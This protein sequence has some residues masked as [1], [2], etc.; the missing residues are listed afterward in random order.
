MMHSAAGSGRLLRQR[1]QPVRR[2]DFITL[3]GGAAAWPLA[4]GAQQSARPVIGYLYGGSAES[5]TP[6]LTGFRRGLMESGYTEGKNVSVE[7][8]WADSQVDRLPKLAE[9]LIRGQVAV[10]PPPVCPLRAQPLWQ[11][12]RSR[13]SYCSLTSPE[14]IDVCL[15]R[16]LPT[17]AAT[18]TISGD[19]RAQC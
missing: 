11:P 5:A 14:V 15:R 2:R 19:D 18:L 17:V 8:R 1:G 16:L 4:A 12:R 9:E 10:S 6:F 13:S 7:Y 3:A